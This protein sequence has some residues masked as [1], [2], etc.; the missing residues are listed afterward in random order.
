MA[1]D[2]LLADRTGKMGVNVIREILKVVSQPGM[3]SLAGGIPAPESVL[4]NGKI[5]FIYLVP[6]FQN[7]TGRTIPLERRREIADIIK[8]YNALLVDFWNG[9]CRKLSIYTVPNRKPCF[10]LWTPIFRRVSNGRSPRAACFSGLR[11]LKASIWKNCT[12]RRSSAMSLLCPASIFIHPSRDQ[13]RFD[14]I[15]SRLESRSHKQKSPCQ[16]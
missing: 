15:E 14:R 13:L 5:K 9:I 7:P 1:F 11:A 10:R 4:A 8:K 12:G 2:H 16:S 3:V 6:T